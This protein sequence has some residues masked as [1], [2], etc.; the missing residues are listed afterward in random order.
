MGI[1]PKA[2]RDRENLG[3]APWESRSRHIA[4]SWGQ[5]CMKLCYLS[6]LLQL[7]N[8]GCYLQVLWE[9][10][11]CALHSI[12][13]WR[14]GRSNLSYHPFPFLLA[15]LQGQPTLSSSSRLPLLSF[16][17]VP[18]R[19]SSQPFIPLSLLLTRITCDSKM[20]NPIMN[21]VFV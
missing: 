5:N 4:S 2:A 13:E 9:C 11:L 15:P 12:T 7:G 16:K 14:E 3:I 1:D 21:A 10:Q 20:L 19:F 18:I 17:P 8:N 6:H